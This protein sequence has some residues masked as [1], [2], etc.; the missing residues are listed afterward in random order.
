VSVGADLL[1]RLVRERRDVWRRDVRADLRVV[2]WRRVLSGAA[3]Q[4]LHRRRGLPRL[5][6]ALE[7]RIARA[8]LLPSAR[9]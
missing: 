5:I 2:L 8:D 9:P 4:S 7:A 6:A 3:D 1:G